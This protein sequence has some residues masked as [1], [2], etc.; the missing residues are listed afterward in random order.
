MSVFDIFI[1]LL[2]CVK[3]D[4]HTWLCKTWFLKNRSAHHHHHH[5]HHHHGSLAY[6]EIPFSKLEFGSSFTSC[7]C[8]KS[9][10]IRTFIWSVFSPNS[11]KYGPEKTPYLNTFRTV[12]LLVLYRNVQK[13]TKPSLRDVKWSNE[14][15]VLTCNQN[16]Y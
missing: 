2:K 12:C 15:V 13:L 3:G 8:V 1:Y 9:V 10:Q 7:H 5:H 11:G 16:H 4:L 6:K 14:T